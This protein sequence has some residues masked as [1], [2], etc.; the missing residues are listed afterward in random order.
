MASTIG[1]GIY[2]NTKAYNSLARDLLKIDPEAYKSAQVALRA[3]T[4]RT[5]SQAAANAGYS[6][7]I[8]QSGKTSV[9]LL[10]AKVT[11][12]GQGPPDAAPIE[13][14]GKGFVRHPVFGNKDNWTAKNSHPA[15]LT[16]AFDESKDEAYAILDE[17]IFSAIDRATGM[18]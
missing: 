1:V 11:F 15:F 9:R 17:A 3:L 7:R 4:K 8:P 16:P 5:L 13:N 2:V 18:I 12:G 6:N 10:K 14:K